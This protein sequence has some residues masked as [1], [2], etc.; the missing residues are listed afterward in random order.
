[1]TVFRSAY[2]RRTAPA[3]L[4]AAI[5]I[6]IVATPADAQRPRARDLGVPFDGTPG[7]ATSVIGESGTR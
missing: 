6:A 3:V 4:A 7:A 5:A 1:M 2:A